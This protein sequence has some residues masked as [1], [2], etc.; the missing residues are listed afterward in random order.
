MNKKNDIRR[1]TGKHDGAT[2]LITKIIGKMI[3]KNVIFLSKLI[4]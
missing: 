3:N 1:I 4:N 2:F